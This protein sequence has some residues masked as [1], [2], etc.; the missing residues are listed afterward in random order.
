M[1][2]LYVEATD[3][4][5]NIETSSRLTDTDFITIFVELSSKA[6][7]FYLIVDRRR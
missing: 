4:P 3:N 2:P 1:G 7:N 5:Y 6:A